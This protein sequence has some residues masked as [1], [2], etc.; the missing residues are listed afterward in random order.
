MLH[1][2]T[3]SQYMQPSCGHHSHKE[4]IGLVRGHRY[5]GGWMRTARSESAAH[6]SGNDLF[7]RC[8]VRSPA[9]ARPRFSVA[10]SRTPIPRLYRSGDDGI[11]ERGFHH[12]VPRRARGDWRAALQP[13]TT[14]LWV[15]RRRQWTRRVSCT[16]DLLHRRCESDYPCADDRS[17][18]QGLR[19]RLIAALDLPTNNRAKNQKFFRREVEDGAH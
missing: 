6:W 16:I 10:P 15:I 5:E 9:G 3:Q 19:C 17:A 2:K 4:G 8:P 13:T 1:E 18:N 7:A 12:S 11:G 14:V